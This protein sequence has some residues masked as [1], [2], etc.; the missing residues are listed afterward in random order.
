MNQCYC[1]FNILE[2]DVSR[3]NELKAAVM[4]QIKER[5][6]LSSTL[7]KRAISKQFPRGVLS[8]ERWQNMLFEVFVAT[9]KEVAALLK[10]LFELLIDSDFFTAMTMMLRFKETCNEAI[11]KY[12]KYLSVP[13]AKD[14]SDNLIRELD[15]C[16]STL[17]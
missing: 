9:L 10:N 3:I 11:R 14:A 5:I 12:K 17:R 6:I 13:L 1:L 16:I 2:K 8:A 4:Q 7:W 15:E